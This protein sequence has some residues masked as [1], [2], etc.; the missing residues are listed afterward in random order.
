[1]MKSMTN[2]SLCLSRRK[3]DSYNNKVI[4]KMAVA[5]LFIQRRKITFIKAPQLR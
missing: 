5:I 4:Y 3:K 1:M 2:D